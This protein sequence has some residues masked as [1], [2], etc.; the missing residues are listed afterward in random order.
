MDHQSLLVGKFNYI[1]F[2]FATQQRLMI[3]LFLSLSLFKNS[4]RIE[5]EENKNLACTKTAKG[6][7]IGDEGTWAA[8]LSAVFCRRTVP[9]FVEEEEEEVSI[10]YSISETLIFTCSVF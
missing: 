9:P 6:V 2:K 10:I 4:R 5:I 1:E 7:F 3:S 8:L